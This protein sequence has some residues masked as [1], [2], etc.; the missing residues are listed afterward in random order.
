MSNLIITVISIVLVA[1]MAVV[2]LL[3]LNPIYS[4]YKNQVFAN[5]MINMGQQLQMA[6]LSYLTNNGQRSY[7]EDLI[8]N[9]GNVIDQKYLTEWPNILGGDLALAQQYGATPYRSNLSCI[10]APLPQW[11]YQIG[12]RYASDAN[13]NNYV[14]IFSTNRN[15]V[16]CG[17][18]S[19]ISESDPTG[20]FKKQDPMF[21]ACKIINK[22][23]DTTGLT[24][25]SDGIPVIVNFPYEGVF[26]HFENMNL[27]AQLKNRC[28]TYFDG[29]QH[30]GYVFV[31]AN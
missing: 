24:L 30:R 6:G 21:N 31:A 27:P 9:L 13:N 18:A 19:Y 17:L 28:Y 16:S 26:G 8:Y 15:D 2:G 11:F 10:P 25:D 5:K 22:N 23:L 7:K 4:N 3:Y 12:Y 1:I 20:I 29:N 14:L